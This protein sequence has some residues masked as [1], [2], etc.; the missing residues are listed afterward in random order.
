M[1][2]YMF[3]RLGNRLPVFTM[4]GIGLVI[5]LTIIIAFVDNPIKVFPTQ[6]LN[7]LAMLLIPLTLCT[8]TRLDKVQRDFFFFTANV[9]YIVA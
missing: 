1:R 5:A 6:G 9:L 8:T 2:Q 4:L 7:E 3:E